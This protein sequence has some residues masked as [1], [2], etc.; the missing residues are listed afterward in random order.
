MKI[1]A[2]KIRWVILTSSFSF[3]FP[4]FLTL[5][6]AVLSWVWRIYTYIQIFFVFK[7]FC[8]VFFHDAWLFSSVFYSWCFSEWFLG[9]C[10]CKVFGQTE[11]GIFFFFFQYVHGLLLFVTL[12]FLFIFFLDASS[13]ISGFFWLLHIRINTFKGWG[14]SNVY[15]QS[16]FWAKVRKVLKIFIWNLYFFQHW[17]IAVYCMGMF[18]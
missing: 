1:I 4:S 5:Y 15:P 14:G 18:S 10:V 9:V 11:N 13:G 3:L 7:K 12:Y 2:C 17:K 16:M 8:G 6:Q